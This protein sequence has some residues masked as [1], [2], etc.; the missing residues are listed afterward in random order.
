MKEST[1]DLLWYIVSW[2]LFAL[3]AA[4]FMF[5]N[6]QKDLEEDRLRRAILLHRLQQNQNQVHIY[7]H[8]EN[9]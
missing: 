8:Q 2:I 7:L 3:F 1:K 6:I 9:K 4:F 5:I